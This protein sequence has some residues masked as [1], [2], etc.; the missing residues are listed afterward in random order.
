M[1]DPAHEADTAQEPI[2]ILFSGGTDSTC[3]AALMAERS[4]DLH[5]LTFTR[6]GF[7]EIEKSATAVQRLVE[8]FPDVQF[9]HKI[10]DV[11]RLFSHLAFKDYLQRVRRFGLRMVQNCTFCALAHH[12]R[13]LGYCLEH[14][15]RVV[16]D[17]ATRELPLLPSHMEKPIARM[18]AL[19]AEYGIDYLTPVYDYDIPREIDFFDKLRMEKD[20]DTGVA[21]DPKDNTTG[22]YLFRLGLLPSQNIKGSALDR[23]MQYRCFQ[24]VLHNMV[25][26]FALAGLED[27]PG[28]ERGMVEFY[29]D[30]IERFKPRPDGSGPLQE[31][32]K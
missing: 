19:Y 2:A 11:D 29:E 18:R 32:M 5:L 4:R 28:Y 17:G 15:I 3:V 23:S 10:I 20:G 13:A 1:T 21:V 8:K 26:Q 9:Q 31:F 30:A 6:H 27:Y 22:Q 16:A 25:A 14:G 24:Y 7:H 12:F